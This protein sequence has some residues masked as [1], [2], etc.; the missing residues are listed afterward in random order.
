MTIN[1]TQPSMP[2]YE[3]YCELIKSI[4]EN[5]HL[6]NNGPLHQELEEKL[7]DY[8][9]VGNVSLVTNGHLALEI[10]IAAL[11]LEGEVITT[12]YT[13]ISTTQ[14]IKRNGLT[15]VFCDINEDD[16]TIDV[17]KI[18]SLIT[19]KTSAIIPVHVYGNICDVEAIDKIAKKYNL[20][21][22][23]DAAH[24][25]GV[26]YNG[27]GVGNFGDISM[28]SFH[29]TKVFNTVEG[30]ALSYNDT[31]LYERIKSLKNFGINQDNSIEYIAGNAKMDEFRAAM[32]ILNLKNINE[33]IEKRK[34]AFDRYFE[35]LEGIEGVSILKY[36]KGLKPNYSYFPIVI[37]KEKYGISRD[38]LFNRLKEQDINTRK[39]FY[40]S[41][42][43][44]KPYYEKK[45]KQNTPISYNVSQNVMCLPLYS[46]LS[47]SEVDFICDMIS[48]NGV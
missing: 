29:A 33:N 3:E 39:Y 17:N 32:G 4:W 18:E 11:E 42:N 15:P 38:L 37:D 28:F 40:P 2:E 5:K 16:F 25:F 43:V 36:R 8:L 1:V 27:V 46:D 6:T 14:A 22:I 31:T 47:L 13:F 12:P 35:N 41:I 48:K 9:K 34:M 26:E 7:T 10:A 20:K 23:Y 45:Y 21:V 24:A 19:E 44:S 30:G